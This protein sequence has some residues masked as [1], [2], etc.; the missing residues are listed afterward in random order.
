MA[1]IR[2]S[3]TEKLVSMAI[4]RLLLVGLLLCASKLVGQVNID[5]PELTESSGLAFSTR[6]EE[7]LFSHNDSGDSARLFAFTV[8]GKFLYELQVEKAKSKDWE[9]MCAFEHDGKNWLAV[10]D[11][12]DNDFREDYVSIYVFKEPKDKEG[13]RKRKAEVEY[14]LKVEYPGGPTNSEALAYDPIRHSF[15]LLSKETLNCAFFEVPIPPNAKGNVRVKAKQVANYTIPLVTGAAI[16]R[17]G[18]RLA[19]CTYGP[20]CLLERNSSKPDKPWEMKASD[21]A[22]KFFQV[23]A[24]RQGEAICFAP[25]GKHLWLTSE[26]SPTPLIELNVQQLKK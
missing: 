23:P 3:Q 8:K 11:I 1:R 26:H 14:E 22:T 7:V 21:V 20:A 2:Y 10:G 4:S 9:D 6:S 13:D 18:H 12:G 17:D 25:D 24:R 5:I 15:L 19:I 16:S